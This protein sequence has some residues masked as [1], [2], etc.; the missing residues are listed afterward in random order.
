MVLRK[1]V[2]DDWHLLLTWRNDPG[3]R[4]NSITSKLISEEEHKQWL[5]L[6][7]NNPN[8]QLFIA[9]DNGLPVG[10]VRA[11]FEAAT[12]FYELSWTVAPDMRG[13]GKGKEMVKM[14]AGQLP[15]IVFA[16]VKK[17]NHSSIKIALWA[18]MELWK[19]DAEIFFFRIENQ[20][21]K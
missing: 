18:G 1:V 11:D 19:E 9:M 14:L 6:A 4:L 17:D 20:C 16:K 3:T 13:K 2:F 10:T 21:V 15:G 5:Q 7:L 8:R 12:G